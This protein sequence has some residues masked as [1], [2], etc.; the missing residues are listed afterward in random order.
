[1]SEIANPYE[2][3]PESSH[4]VAD[5]APT[6]GTRV[7]DGPWTQ[8]DL[9]VDDIAEFNLHLVKRSRLNRTQN[10]AL[11]LCLGFATLMALPWLLSP[12]I[13]WVL[14]IP[15]GALSLISILT[16]LLNKT[17]IRRN[18]H[19][20]MCEADNQ[21]MLGIQEL[22]RT[23]DAI[24]HRSIACESRYLPTAFVRID[25]TPRYWFLFT[26]SLHAIIVPKQSIT[27][28]DALAVMN[29]IQTQPVT[30]IA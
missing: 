20:L 27:G 9:D 25:D 22:Q 17:V 6:L 28:G 8:F 14:L 3:P 19:K 4:S 24:V 13:P 2:T 16:R 18:V 15:I 29:G 23:N 12:R 21:N 1:M 5:H 7:E 10:R 30:P 26:S 11:W